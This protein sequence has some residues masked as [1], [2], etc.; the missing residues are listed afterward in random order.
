MVCVGC[1]RGNGDFRCKGASQSG[2]RPFE[3]QSIKLETWL[4]KRYRVDLGYFR[5][6]FATMGD[7]EV[8]LWLYPAENPSGVVAIG[9]CVTVFI[10]RYAPQKTLA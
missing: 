2:C 9:G 8:V 4:P 7:T 1:Y 5:K 10:A 6:E 3:E